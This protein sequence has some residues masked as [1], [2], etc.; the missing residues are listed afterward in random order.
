MKNLTLFFFFFGISA[1]GFSQT[2][3]SVFSA[4]YGNNVVTVRYV[5]Q[6]KRNTK[7]EFIVGLGAFVPTAMER[8]SLAYARSLFPT[9]T[10]Q[11]IVPELEFRRYFPKLSSSER[12]KAFGFFEQ[13]FSITNGLT[14]KNLEYNSQSGRYEFVRSVWPER[15]ISLE[16]CIGVGVKLQVSNNLDFISKLGGSLSLFKADN[17]FSAKRIDYDPYYNFSFGLRYRFK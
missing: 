13:R 2:I 8:T 6:F 16:N 11:Y 5:K 14:Y 7:M 9:K 3:E 1:S 12:F 4:A 15:V 17:S 10:W